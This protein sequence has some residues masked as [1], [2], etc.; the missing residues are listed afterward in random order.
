MGKAKVETG[1]AKV[2]KKRS[3]TM[4]PYASKAEK[5]SHVPM[6][7]S[8]PSTQGTNMTDGELEADLRQVGRKLSVFRNI[9]LTQDR[10]NNSSIDRYCIPKNRSPKT[11]AEIC[12]TPPTK[13]TGK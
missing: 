11:N 1:K 8:T 9:N 4:S 10:D 12:Y 13:A 5:V 6:E 7:P 2:E 3:K